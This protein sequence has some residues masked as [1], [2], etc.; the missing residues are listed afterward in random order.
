MLAPT[1]S[2]FD[3]NKEESLCNQMIKDKKVDGLLEFD[4]KD[5]PNR[6]I[7][8]HMVNYFKF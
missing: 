1:P 7:F 6:P 3:R 2:V 8:G 4:Q 5:G